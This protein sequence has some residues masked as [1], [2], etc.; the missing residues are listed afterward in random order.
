MRVTETDQ[1]DHPF[2]CL[3]IRGIKVSEHFMN[4]Y[5]MLHVRLHDRVQTSVVALLLNP[6]L[7]RTCSQGIFTVM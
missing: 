5:C 1:W 7:C 3:L 2:R 6:P 4:E